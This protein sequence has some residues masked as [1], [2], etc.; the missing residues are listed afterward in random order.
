MVK[1]RTPLVIGTVLL[2]TALAIARLIYLPEAWVSSVV[3]L[4]FLPLAIAILV[5]RSRAAADTEKAR[6]MSGRLRA[7]LVGAGVLLGTALLLSITDELGYTNQS[8]SSSG[9]SILVLL[10]AIIATGA[11]LFSTWLEKQAEKDPD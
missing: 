10:P 6:T 3:A 9:F 4:V 2:V 5:A 1:L 8:G 11:D 7:A